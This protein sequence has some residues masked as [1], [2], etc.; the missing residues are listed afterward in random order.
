MA[1]DNQVG[2][3]GNT[4]ASWGVVMDTKNGNVGIGIQTNAPAAK[5]DVGGAAHASSFPTSSDERFKRDITPLRDCLEKV[6]NLRGI[7]FE[8]NDLYESMGRSTHHREIGVI[9]QEVELQF[10]ELVTTWG[11]QRVGVPRCE[12]SL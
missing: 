11:N 12:H 5:L 6:G 9:A 1:T 2:F 8:W 3:W 7:S 10:P 4:G